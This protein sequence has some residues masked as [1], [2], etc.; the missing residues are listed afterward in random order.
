[1]SAGTQRSCRAFPQDKFE[2]LNA[3]SCRQGVKKASHMVILIP[4]VFLVWRWL[5][6]I[7]K[8]ARSPTR[9][10]TGCASAITVTEWQSTG[11]IFRLDNAAKSAG[12]CSD[13]IS[14]AAEDTR[15]ARISAGAWVIYWAEGQWRRYSG[16]GATSAR[17][18]PCCRG[19]EKGA[20][21]LFDTGPGRVRIIAGRACRP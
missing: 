14:S 19:C 3:L 4:A 6:T 8:H 1:M 10:T 12:C 21:G 18:Q 15:L 11:L 13:G 2:E 20:D 5:P 7:A 9:P 16:D 17:I